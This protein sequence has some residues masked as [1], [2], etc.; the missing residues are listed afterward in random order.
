METSTQKQQNLHDQ[1][2]KIIINHCYQSSIGIP[3]RFGIS[4]FSLIFL[5]EILLPLCV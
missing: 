5:F 2:I 4:E 3:L 1:I